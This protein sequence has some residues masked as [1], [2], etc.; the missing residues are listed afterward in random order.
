MAEIV[1]LRRARKA[2]LRREDEKTAAANRVQFGTAKRHRENAQSER[3]KAVREI[4]G[5]KLEGDDNA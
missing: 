3:E 1:N 4:E 5:H 2:K